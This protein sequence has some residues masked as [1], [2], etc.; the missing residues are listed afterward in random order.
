[1]TLSS[2]RISIKDRRENIDSMIYQ[3]ENLEQEKVKANS[4]F[5]RAQNNLLLLSNGYKLPSRREILDALEGL[6]KWSE[7]V[8]EILYT[9]SDL[10]FKGS[11]VE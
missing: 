5:R 11:Q 10:Y 8:I 6:D 1:M 2:H 9:L 4:N 3:R 7:S